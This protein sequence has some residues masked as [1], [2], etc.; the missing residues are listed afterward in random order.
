MDLSPD[1]TPEDLEVFLQ[2]TEEQLELLDEDIVRLER[3]DDTAPLLQEIFRAAHT[4]KGSAGMIGHHRMADLA[5]SMEN[6]L[7][8]LRLGTT[9]VSTRI[10]DALLGGLDLL[11]AMKDD[12]TNSRDTQIDISEA[13][14]VL[15]SLAASDPAHTAKQV[16]A[17]PG[18]AG[19]R[20][21]AENEERVHVAIDAGFRVFLAKTNIDPA[22]EWVSIRCFQ[23]VDALAQSSDIII[24]SPS[25]AE[26]GQ[27]KGSN[28]VQAILSTDKDAQ[29]F[30]LA[31]AAIDEVSGIEVTELDPEDTTSEVV[32]NLLSESQDRPDDTIPGAPD[33][34]SAK[35]LAVVG[36]SA[37]NNTAEPA[38]GNGGQPRTVCRLKRYGSMSNASTT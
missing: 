24:S 20:L 4:L 1:I 25:L 35:E 14:S 32:G 30:E 7:D 13:V 18:A 10:V 16:S 5:H 12:L 6:I 37:K 36:A 26:I 11:R 28:L 21:D 9:G 29:T 22:S 33:D 17:Q 15:D 38:G 8:Q 19:L 34:S 31:L 27:E 23:I 3:E 2:E